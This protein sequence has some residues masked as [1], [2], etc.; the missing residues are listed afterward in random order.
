MTLN[1]NP[2]TRAYLSLMVGLFLTLA[3]VQL[4]GAPATNGQQAI[5]ITAEGT[6]GHVAY[7]IDSQPV[8]DLLLSQPP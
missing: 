7:K 5:V 8:T 4:Q 6:R 1:S 2:T 3:S